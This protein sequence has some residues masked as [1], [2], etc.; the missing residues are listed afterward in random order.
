MS[1]AGCLIAISDEGDYITG[2]CDYHCALRRGRPKCWNENH[3]RKCCCFT[4][5]CNIKI[6]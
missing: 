6:L 5:L 3:Q 4:H 1:G 2:G